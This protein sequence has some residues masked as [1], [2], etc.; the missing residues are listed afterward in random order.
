MTNLFI[1]LIISAGIFAFI[2]IFRI[3][4]TFARVINGI[5][6]ASIGVSFIPVPEIAIDGYY[7]FAIGCLLVILYAFSDSDFTSLKKGILISMG[8]IQL[9]G[10]A[11]LLGKYPHVD[12]IFLGGF[13]TIGIYIFAVTKKIKLFFNEIGFMTVLMIDAFIKCMMVLSASN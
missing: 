12:L 7:L 2:Q 4:D 5:L 10:M 13:G 8:G 6:A 11:F 3:K 1:S 9:L